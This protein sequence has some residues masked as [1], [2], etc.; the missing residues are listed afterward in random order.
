MKQY[1]A[2][3]ASLN[4]KV[5]KYQDFDTQAEADAHVAS[6]GGFVSAKPSD[7]TGYWVVGDGTLTHDA[8]QEAADADEVASTQYQRDR[9]YPPMG[10]QLDAL[11]KGGADADA[12]KAT[13]ATVKA[14]HPKPGV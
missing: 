6:F 11:W 13:I 3:V 4:G 14:T 12:M 8:A 5:A 9:E 7:S 1:I 2:I 10:D